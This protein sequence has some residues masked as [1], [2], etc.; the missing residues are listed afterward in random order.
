MVARSK[1]RVVKNHAKLP[2]AGANLNSVVR[3]RAALGCRSNLDQD[4]QLSSANFAFC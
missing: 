1:K 2:C 4:F 3:N